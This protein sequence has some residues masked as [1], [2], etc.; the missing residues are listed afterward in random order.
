MRFALVV[1]LFWW[2]SVF[3]DTYALKGT[4]VT[5]DTVIE[6]GVLL[7]RDGVIVA[8]GADVTLPEDVVAIDTG[9]FI[10][11]GL[12]DLHNHLTWNVLRR[13]YAGTLTRNRYEWQAMDS[14]S[15]GLRRVQSLLFNYGCDAERFAEVKAL[16][17]GGTSVTG[18]LP[19]DCSKGLARNLDYSNGLGTDVQYRVFPLELNANDEKSVRDA[20]A[21]KNAVIVHL[22]EGIDASAARE[23]RMASAHGFFTEGFVM[24]HGVPLVESDWKALGEK[25]VGFVWSPRSNVELYGKTA[26]AATAAKYV[27][28]AIAPDW[29]PSGSNGMI[30]ELR[31]AMLLTNAFTAKQLVQMATTNPAKLARLSGK[32]GC[33]APSCAAD[34]VV[35]RHGAR[36]DPYETLI[37][38]SH[39]AMALVAVNGR[40][41]YGDAD[42]IKLVNPSARVETLTVC[43]AA[44]GVDTSD[45]DNSAG[46]TWADTMK[47]LTTA[48]SS[49][50][51]PMAGLA[52]CWQ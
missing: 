15:V 47:N 7:V 8:A 22:A 14:Y 17:W 32:I 37:Y 13:W 21:A 19:K 11:P 6:N 12:I 39:D 31:Y 3:A 28:T 10:Y 52:E 30:E 24:I 49:I 18:S 5:P 4:L 42:L 29:S 43:G 34:Y 9:G 35:V 48:F 44:K 38:A 36:T 41:L 33:L 51:V 1:A 23:V 25:N 50:Q 27:T 26:D 16:V 2:S 45:S 20:L 40:P 46:V